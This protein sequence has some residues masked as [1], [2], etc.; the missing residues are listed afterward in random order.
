MESG[1]KELIDVLKIQNILVFEREFRRILF[2][3]KSLLELRLVLE[4][5]DK[6]WASLP[7]NIRQAINNAIE[8]RESDLTHEQSTIWKEILELQG[9]LKRYDDIINEKRYLDKMLKKHSLIPDDEVSFV[10][11][12]DASI[13]APSEDLTKD[14]DV[15]FSI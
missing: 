12:F 4:M 11:L 2:D 9:L 5:V 1:K 15:D 7:E 8:S 6:Q 10:S 14:D 3:V 13:Y